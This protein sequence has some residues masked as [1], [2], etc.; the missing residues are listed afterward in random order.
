LT[1]IARVSL[2]PAPIEN[3]A[4]ELTRRVSVAMLTRWAKAL[5]SVGEYQQGDTLLAVACRLHNGDTT[6]MHHLR[7]AMY[8]V[9]RADHARRPAA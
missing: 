5:H 3:A 4:L 9:R 1:E 7:T 2:L 6:A 8:E